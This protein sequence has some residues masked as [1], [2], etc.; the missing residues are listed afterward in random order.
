MVMFLDQRAQEALS[1]YILA[2]FG[3]ISVRLGSC[4][5]EEFDGGEL[6]CIF[7][8]SINFGRSGAPSGE[9]LSTSMPIEGFVS[10]HEKVYRH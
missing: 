1:L 7:I 6:L 2:I 9:C 3:S 4:R 8:G 5:K 10:N